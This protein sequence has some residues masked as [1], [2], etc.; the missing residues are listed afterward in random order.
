MK[1]SKLEQ[2]YKT[3]RFF[4]YLIPVAA[5]AVGSYLVLFPIDAYRFYPDD[6]NASKFEFEKSD[7]N[8]SL[9]FGIF[10]LRES[11]FVDVDLGFK[12]SEKASCL[13]M[14]AKIILQKTYKAFLLPEGD[15]ISNADQLRGIIFSENNTTYPNG[16]LLHVK[17][18][19]QVFLISDG[20]KTLFPGPEIFAAF[21]Y[22]FDNLVEVDMAT[23]DEFKDADTAVFLWNM[24]HPDGTVFE[25]YPSHKLYIILQG[26]RL[27]IV[28]EDILKEVWPNFYSIAV[29]DEDLSAGLACQP[30]SRAFSNDSFC[31]FDLGSLAGI[32]RY[33]LFT[34]QFPESC[35]VANVHPNSSKV[36]YISDKS[37][38]NIKLSM[39]NIAASILNRYFYKFTNSTK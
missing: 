30:F 27:P 10:P 39:K 20:K 29:G 2:L 32:G 24:P 3:L 19:N 7:Q 28:S 15:E 33:N 36:S 4:V 18:T 11:R 8:N 5:V 26:K 12:K 25:A 22:S 37:I 38:E 31:R 16:S 17:A 1:P 21:G 14:P 13:T 23:I 6:P 34:V 35:S 9:S